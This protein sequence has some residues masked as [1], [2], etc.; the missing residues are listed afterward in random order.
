MTISELMAARKEA[1]AAA[2]VISDKAKTDESVTDEEC[3]EG[4][5]HVAEARRLNEEIKAAE[6]RQ[7]NALALGKSIADENT[8]DS[9]TA[10]RVS[11]PVTPVDPV[12]AAISNPVVVGGEASDKFAH[13]GEYLFKVREAAV[14][15]SIT[16]SRLAPMAAAP[17][18]RT[19]VDSLGGFLIPDQFAGGILEKM[20]NTGE[21]LSRVKAAGMVLPLQGNTIKLPRV[22]ESS[23]AT[24]SRSGGVQGYWVGETAAVSD[25]KP[26]VG[27]LTLTLHKAGALGYITEE[28]LEDASAS[29]A[30]LERLLTKELIF[31]VEDSIVNGNGANKPLGLLA[32]NC[33]ISQAKMTNQTAATIW[34][35]NLTSMWARMYAPSR[36]T[37]VW[38]ANQS[39]EPFL[40][41]ATLEGRYG[42][43]A[44]S[45]DG[46]PL[47]YPAGSLLNQGSYG[48]L[49]GRPVIFVEYTKKVGTV[50]DIILWDP[51]SYALAEKAGGGVRTASSIHVRFLTDEM[52]FRAIYRVDGQPTWD[53]ALTPFDAGNTLSP[54]VTL[55]VR[56]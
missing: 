24:G 38:L 26:K 15:P 8:L 53:Q 56:S 7:A 46:I 14:S 47:Y 16:D 39:I 45:A 3:A 22:D 54:I 31:T 19:D 23:R 29:G 20:Y 52:T 27:Q 11:A 9:A 6:Q 5:K 40:W 37:A 44:G 2:Q 18:M 50:G 51:A 32:A 41:S 43:A 10:R 25:S 4:E 49:M 1:L 34:G 13:F 35:D 55:A 21:L 17:G 30:F 33:T 48:I 42:S 28:M 12:A 36:S